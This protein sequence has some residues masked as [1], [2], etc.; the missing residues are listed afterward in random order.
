MGNKYLN[1]K[2]G[3]N[4]I[5]SKCDEVIKGNIDNIMR[6]EANLT[7]L[8]KRDELEFYHKMQIK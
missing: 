2:M 6:S 1:K 8:L 5:T 3:V 7:E 4:Q